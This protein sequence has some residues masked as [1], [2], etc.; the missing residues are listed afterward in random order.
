[1]KILKRNS[2]VV[3]CAVALLLAGQA[4]W[5]QQVTVPARVVAAVDETQTVTLKGNVHPLARAEFDQGAVSDAT[6]A[7][8]MMLLLQRSPEQETALRQLLDQQQDKTS[9]NYHAWLTPAQF[10]TQFGPADADVQAVTGWLQS[11]GF[12]N[13]K[14]GA[15]RTTIEFSGNVGQVRNAFHTDI[16]QYL[17]HGEQHMA[18]VSDPQIPAALAPVLRGVL[19][20]HNFRPK[21]LMHRMT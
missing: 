1:M 16:H 13:V 19:G 10:G 3:L 21:S 6:P 7:T 18:N 15:G 2:W 14:V 11:H 17:V 5:A 8:R 20:L 9:A 12:Q 4:A